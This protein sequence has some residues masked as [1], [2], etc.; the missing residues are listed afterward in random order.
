MVAVLVYKELLYRGGDSCTKTLSVEYCKNDTNMCVVSVFSEWVI[1]WSLLNANSIICQLYHGENKFL[2]DR[3]LLIIIKRYSET[4]LVRFWKNTRKIT[5]IYYISFFDT[6][7]KWGAENAGV[8][9]KPDFPG[10]RIICLS[11]ATILSVDRY[12]NELVLYKYIPA[13]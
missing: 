7:M 6:E 13:F 11:G 5:C 12:F 8:R 9:T 2:V 3:R 10:I 4:F 1:E